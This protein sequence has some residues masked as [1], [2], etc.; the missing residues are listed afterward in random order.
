MEL[1]LVG[2]RTRSRLHDR[3]GGRTDRLAVH[4]ANPRPTSASRSRTRSPRA[5]WSPPDGRPGER[6]R[7]PMPAFRQPAARSSSAAG[8]RTGSPMARW[9][10]VGPTWTSFGCSSSSGLLPRRPDHSELNLPS[11]GR[12]SGFPRSTS[13]AATLRIPRDRRQPATNASL[14]DPAFVANRFRIDG[15]PAAREHHGILRTTFPAGPLAK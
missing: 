8:A 7:A 14:T 15:I 10:S 12:T 5:I 3:G 11:A 9:S 2:R 13:V 4:P 1:E 6:R